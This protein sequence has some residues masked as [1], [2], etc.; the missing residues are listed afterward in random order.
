MNPIC[1]RIWYPRIVHDGDFAELLAQLKNIRAERVYLFDNGYMDNYQLSDRTLAE[2]VPVLRRRIR[3][4]AD[5]GILAGINSGAT[6]G[7]GGIRGFADGWLDRRDIEWWTDA[8]GEQALGIACPIGTRFRAFVDHYFEQLARTGAREIF[9]DDDMRPMNHAPAVSELGCLCDNHIAG[10]GRERG[11]EFNR[12]ELVD[13][14][15]KP[16]DGRPSELQ[17]AWHA[18]WGKGFLQLAQLMRNAVDRIDPGIRLGLMPVQNFMMPFGADYFNEMLAIVSG[19]HRPLLRTHNFH[20]SPRRIHPGSAI[21]V[22]LNTPPATEHVVEIENCGHNFHDFQRCPRH[23][24]YAVL[25]AL[26]TGMGGAS[27]N[28]LGDQP[29]MMDW[30]RHHIA[31]FAA[32]DEVYRT[33]SKLTGQGAVMRGVPVR[34]PSFNRRVAA[35]DHSAGLP[36]SYIWNY[37]TAPE[38]MLSPIGISYEFTDDAPALL[39]GRMPRVLGA[40]VVE[41]ILER[42]AVIDVDAARAIIEMGLG[43]KL[44]V[45]IDEPINSYT[46]QHFIDPEF[47]GGY[48]GQIVPLRR[49][50][51]IHSLKYDPK[52]YRE[53]T[54][55]EHAHGASA[56]V[57]VL[58]RTDG[59]ARI[60]IMPYPLLACLEPDGSE[61]GIVVCRHHRH[62]LVRLFEWV[63]RSP[64]PVWIDGP[65]HLAPYYFLRPLDKSAVLSLFNPDP[66]EQYDF[67]IVL[68]QLNSDTLVKRVMPDGRLSPMPEMKIEN[69]RLRISRAQALA[70]CD[71]AVFTFEPSR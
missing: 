44:G 16:W 7:H 52:I 6:I 3:Q 23:T 27:I 49:I 67:D 71:V 60:C 1:F 15:S 48:A 54:R 68:G 9:I 14:L 22:R 18:F 31:D 30:E 40:K 50:Y 19:S 53:V 33:I 41:Q 45:T 55:I 46:G 26:A 58:A 56:T 37:Q 12:A 20:G 13:H 64:L 17:T 29:P 51:R 62:L 11:I 38:M 25:T 8:D 43:D 4:F 21:Y 34:N 32:N 10:F 47:C 42:G 57:G 36:S 63:M 39:T 70:P 2:R 24:R 61:A 59:P 69:H 28:I 65:P 5:E 35:L 66:D